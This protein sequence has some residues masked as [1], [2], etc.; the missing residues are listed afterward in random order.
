V[1]DPSATV[2][3][4]VFLVERGVANGSDLELFFSEADALDAAQRYLSPSWLG[5]KS[6]SPN[7][8]YGLIEAANQEPGGDEHL[9]VAPFPVAGRLAIH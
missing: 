1:R 6:E 3:V 2:E 8:V 9:L 5:A 7:D 4:W